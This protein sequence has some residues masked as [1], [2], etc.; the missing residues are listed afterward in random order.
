M[1][2]SS[3]TVLEEV[4]RVVPTESVG[5]VRG[6]CGA[7]LFPGEDVDK[8]VGVLSGGEKARVCLARILV[9]PGNLLVMD[10]PTNHLDL[11]SSEA[12]IDALAE[13]NGT[14]LFVSHNRSFINRLATKIWDVS[15]G[16]VEEYPGTLRE[17]EVHIKAREEAA[18][19]VEGFLYQAAEGGDAPGQANGRRQSRKE[20]RRERAEQ[21]RLLQE[22]LEPLEG[23]LRSVEEKISN[24]ESRQGEIEKD[25]AEPELFRDQ[26][27]SVPL[28][29]E[30]DLL[31]EE[32]EELMGEWEKKQQELEA[33]KKELGL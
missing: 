24:L 16:K 22:R 13:Y 32:L 10:E 19:P 3:R 4:Y 8:A 1:L 15:G 20:L 2:D 30:Y 31:R 29:R 6:V 17:Y 11:I 12:L 7:F 9:K 25:L 26:A 14:I 5:F 28:L 18:S 21:R 33:A 27:R 23:S